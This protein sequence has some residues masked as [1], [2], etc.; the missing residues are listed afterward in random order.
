MCWYISVM[1]AATLAALAEPTRLRIVEFLRINPAP[2]GEIAE[3][4][5]IRQPQVSKHLKILSDA[6]WVEA[7]PRAQKRVYQLQSKPF[8][9]LEVWLESFRQTWE[10]NYQRLDSLLEEMKTEGKGETP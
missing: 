9:D 3:K 4:L 1:N 6:G 8:A 10:A 2:V 7:Q 5:V